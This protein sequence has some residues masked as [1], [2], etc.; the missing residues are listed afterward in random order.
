M[1]RTKFDQSI[2]SAGWRRLLRIALLLPAVIDFYQ[3][4][5]DL[6]RLS[7]SNDSIGIIIPRAHAASPGQTIHNTHLSRHQQ[8][9]NGI[10]SNC[11]KSCGEPINSEVEGTRDQ[12]SEPR[13]KDFK[14]FKI[15]GRTP[16][17]IFATSKRGKQDY[18][19]ETTRLVGGA[20]LNVDIDEEAPQQ[21]NVPPIP[22]SDIATRVDQ[23]KKS[24]L[25]GRRFQQTL[26]LTHKVSSQAGPAL[27]TLISLLCF[28]NGKKDEISLLT[29]YTL[30]LL[31]ASCGFHLFLHFITLGYALGVTLPLIVAL[32]FY[33]VCTWTLHHD[34]WWLYFQRSQADLNCN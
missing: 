22:Q 2:S 34:L 20:N 8:K 13:Q 14:P 5:G 15:F 6:A 1:N 3:Y 28:N 21:E 27:I 10:L 31:G 7:S 32:R 11:H 23:P 29:L 4:H 18:L 9:H 17:R 16:L 12:I 26:V 25:V 33:Q 24:E 30:A 19:R